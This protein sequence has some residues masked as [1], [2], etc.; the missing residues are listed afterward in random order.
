MI[1]GKMAADAGRI[2]E[3][4]DLPELRAFARNL[5]ET[6]H[7]QEARWQELLDVLEEAVCVIDAAGTVT[8]WNRRSEKLYDIPADKILGQPIEL[9]FSNLLLTRAMKESLTVRETYLN[10]QP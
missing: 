7:M 2:I 3:S 4:A 5:L 8:G 6:C 10:G 1:E 9:F